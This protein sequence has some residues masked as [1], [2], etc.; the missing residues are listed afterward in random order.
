MKA[1]VL[2][3]EQ[4]NKIWKLV[5]NLSSV[6]SSS[7]WVDDQLSHDESVGK[8][9]MMNRVNYIIHKTIESDFQFQLKIRLVESIIFTGIT[10]LSTNERIYEIQSIK[11]D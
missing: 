1:T 11:Y 2:L 4:G 3:L 10:R 5:M 7:D 9:V 6:W 8:Y